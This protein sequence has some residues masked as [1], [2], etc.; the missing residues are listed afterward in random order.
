MQL[1]EEMRCLLT[2]PL[3]RNSD[4][5][6]YFDFM[7]HEAGDGVLQGSNEECGVKFSSA[8]KADRLDYA[9]GDYLYEV[10][11]NDSGSETPKSQTSQQ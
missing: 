8:G 6:A 3:V 9:T 1:V 4:E 5:A 2:T 11:E 7:R 10:M